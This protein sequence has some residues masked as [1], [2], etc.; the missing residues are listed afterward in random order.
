M[1]KIPIS[2]KR[3][4]VTLILWIALLT[5]VFFLSLHFLSLNLAI[6]ISR[7]GNV[8]R[9]LRNFMIVDLT[10]LS[11]I[12]TELFVSIC[13][14]IEGLALGFVLSIPL[15]FLGAENTTPHPVV[16]TAIKVM[17]SIIRAIPA[18]VWILM[19]VSSLGFGNTAGVIG[20]VFSTIGYLVKSFISSIE[21]QNPA[22]IETMN[23]TGA[24]WFQMITEGLLPNLK[25]SFL[26]W[27]SIRLEANIAQ[28][29]SMGMI[30]AGGI[31]MLLVRAT[32]QYDYGTVSTIIISIFITMLSVEFLIGKVKRRIR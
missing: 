11:E 26:S 22:I 14:A 23:A 2:T 21:E 20:I 3:E 24:G 29:I 32:G 31:G 30:G 8:G 18:L 25:N 28:S 6:F 15:S 19:I 9:V 1:H 13:I 7:F 12:L 16:A 4:K 27:S 5:I 10:D 17:V